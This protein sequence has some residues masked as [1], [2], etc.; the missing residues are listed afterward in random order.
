MLAAKDPSNTLWQRELWF[1]TNEIGEVLQDQGDLPG[2]LAAYR[3]G[4]AIAKALAAKDPGIAER[5][6]RS[7]GQRPEGSA[8]CSRPRKIWRVPSPPIATLSRSGEALAAKNPGNIQLQHELSAFDTEVGD[9]LLGQHDLPEALAVYRD[10]FAIVKVLAAKDPGNTELQRDLLLSY[11]RFGVI[12]Y[13]QEDFAGALDAF[14]QAETIA[15]QVKAANPTAA[16]STGDLEWVQTH[17]AATREKL[18]SA[19]DSK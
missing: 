16:T 19:G 8:T 5:Q 18:A 11:E 7:L 15:L 2:A 6:R 14:E 4:L 12:A 1:T 17:L 9:V 10:A 3:D 13:L